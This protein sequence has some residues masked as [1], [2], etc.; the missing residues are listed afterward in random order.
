MQ[1]ILPREKALNYGIE[2]LNDI[3]LLSLILKSG[4]KGKSVFKL[5]EDII[6]KANG[7]E[8]LMSFKYDELISINGLGKA[9]AL[10]LLAIIEVSKRLTKL[11]KIASDDFTNPNELAN[12][13]KFNLAFSS[14]EEFFVIYLNSRGK[15]LKSEI[16]FKGSNR[17]AVIGIDEIIRRALLLKSS[18]LVVAHNHPGGN[19]SPSSKDIDLTKK[20]NESLKLMN[21]QLLDHIIVT[22]GSYFSFRS[23][24]LL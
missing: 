19:P 16:L 15:V 18:N 22:Q 2:V 8:N 20:L 23:K 14:Q 4:Y 17:E 10:E 7:I 24:D 13:I 5:A 21:M 3:E 6:D 1:E 11:D 9:K 12:W